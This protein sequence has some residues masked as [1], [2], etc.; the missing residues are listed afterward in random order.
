MRPDLVE[1]APGGANSEISLETRNGG[2]GDAM[3]F[4]LGL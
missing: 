4:S 2:I 1:F 3:E